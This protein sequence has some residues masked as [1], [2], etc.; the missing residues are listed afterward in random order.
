MESGND[1]CQLGEYDRKNVYLQA[2]SR[3][4]SKEKGDFMSVTLHIITTFSFI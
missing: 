3:E 1:F 4:R 2:T